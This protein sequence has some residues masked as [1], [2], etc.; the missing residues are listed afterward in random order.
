MEQILSRT[1]KTA[2]RCLILIMLLSNAQASAQ[3][4]DRRILDEVHLHRAASLDNTMNAIGFSAYPI[5]VALPLAQFIHGFAGHHEQSLRYGLQSATALIAATALT[6]G[7]K[8][9]VQRQRP[10]IGHPEYQPYSTDTSP[11][12]PSGHTSLAFE[13]ATTLSI[14]YPKWYVIIPSYAWAGAVGYSRIH[15]GEHYPS[16]VLAGALVGAASAYISYEGNK[17]LR[18][19]W[20]K[21]IPQLAD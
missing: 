19:V 15:L 6:Y 4:L 9:S 2:W 3:N 18:K 13:T 17:W 16:D 8:Y 10:F 5:A 7:L 20:K 14:E 12:F 11:S 21:K 1:T